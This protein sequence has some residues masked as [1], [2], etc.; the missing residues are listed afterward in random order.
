MLA[1]ARADKVLYRQ[2][3]GPE[4]LATI[5]REY[6]KAIMAQ[7][8]F[9]KEFPGV[10]TWQNKLHSFYKRNRYVETFLGFRRR[11]P[12]DYTKIINTPIQGTAFH[13]LLAGLVEA[14]GLMAK[15]R[16][17]SRIVSQVH[18]SILV[19]LFSEEVV[20]VLSI[21]KMCLEKKRYDWMGDVPMEV[22]W[23][24]G[25]NWCDMEEIDVPA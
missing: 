16:L 9:W 3:N 12:L 18:D 6:G 4:E 23:S 8:D 1:V 20:E 15:A 14:H 13:L 11:A 2:I 19:D 22:E 5:R 25:S 17:K 7:E 24:V 10:K 21:L